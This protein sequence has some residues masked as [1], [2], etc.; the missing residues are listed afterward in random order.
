[1]ET[2]IYERQPKK[3]NKLLYWRVFSLIC[4]YMGCPAAFIMNYYGAFSYIG[5]ANSLG[6]GAG[7]AA[8]GNQL[9]YFTIWSNIVAFFW[10][11]TA[12]IAEI[13]DNKK[14]KAFVEY[15]AVKCT[16]YIMML[17]TMVVSFVILYPIFF[18]ISLQDYTDTITGEFH[19]GMTV[20]ASLIF[21]LEMAFVSPLLFQ[22]FLVS[23]VLI[24]DM[25][26]TKGYR[27]EG[28]KKE[29][30]K[31]FTKALLLSMIIPIA[32]LLPS[33]IYI[34]LG[35]LTPQYPFMY[36]FPWVDGAPETT[37]LIINWIILSM[38][39]VCWFA[40]YGALAKYSNKK[41]KLD[42]K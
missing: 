31:T 12:L 1:M 24:V 21:I 14:M 30:G 19:E 39:F 26:L 2:T 25:K 40:V 7:W 10:V 15:P 33:I 27:P 11:T 16:P 29:T 23:I 18:L 20:G 3:S 5:G 17:I 32:W 8:I 36:L 34:G 22:H 13:F 41:Y 38:I 28:D 37:G 6:E 42:N 4:V 35:Y 9:V